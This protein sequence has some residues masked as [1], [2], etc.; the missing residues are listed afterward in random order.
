MLENISDMK[1]LIQCNWFIKQ[2]IFTDIFWFHT[3]YPIKYS[4]RHN[5]SGQGELPCNPIECEFPICLPASWFNI[6]NIVVKRK[7][8]QTWCLKHSDLYLFLIMFPWIRIRA[9]S[10]HSC[11]T[12]C[13]PVDC[14]LP[15]SCDHGIL[16][17]RIL[18]WGAISYSR[19]SSQPRD[20]TCVSYVS[21]T[22]RRV[23]YH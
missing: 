9:K 2:T 15:G 23:L 22:G 1:H 6:R 13:D 7:E 12:L 19:G 10:L 3:L 5:I 8:K 14:S 21:C 4:P 20:R 11:P 16:Q 17:A 18:E